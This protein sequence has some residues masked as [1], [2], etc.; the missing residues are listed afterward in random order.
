MTRPEAQT[1]VE[2]LKAKFGGEAETE[3]VAP[4]RFRFAIVSPQFTNISPLQRQ[5]QI[6]ELVDAT[7]NREQRFDVSLILA[8]A[9]DDVESLE[10]Y[11]VEHT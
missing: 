5:D 1:L 11:R 9:P 6:W 2:S 10:W 8:F 3:E 4:G 7:L